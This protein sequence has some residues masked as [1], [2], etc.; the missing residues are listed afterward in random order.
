[1]EANARI[2]RM[3]E[4]PGPRGGLHKV[5]EVVWE[6]HAT[7]LADAEHQYLDPIWGEDVPWGAFNRNHRT[8]WIAK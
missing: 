2:E 7:C 3:R 4:V 6:G 8:N 1:M 5:W